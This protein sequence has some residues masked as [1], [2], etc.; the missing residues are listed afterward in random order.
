MT[1]IIMVR[2]ALA[3]GDERQRDALARFCRLASLLLSPKHRLLLDMDWTS[4]TFFC[5]L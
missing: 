4:S 1:M 3:A 2:A 5:F